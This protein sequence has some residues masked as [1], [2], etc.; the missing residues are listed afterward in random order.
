M[1]IHAFPC[2]ALALALAPP[3]AA[4]TATAEPAIP[5]ALPASAAA[6]TLS[7]GD[8]L[9]ITVWRKPELSGDFT[10]SADSTIGSPFYMDLKVTGMP[11]SSVADRV[12]THIAR[13]E[14]E[15]R[16]LVE[17]LFRVSIAGEVRQP[18]LYSVRPETTIAQAIMKSGGPTI[19]ARLDRVVLWRGGQQLTVDLTRPDAG[20]AGSPIRSGDQLLV[21]RRTSILRDYVAPMS[22]VIGASAAIAN[23]ILRNWR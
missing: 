19:F 12:R 8:E 4:Q 11:L 21:P 7:P 3:L 18:N 20:L 15:P 16:V 1:R 10:I 9:R 13:Y 22:S 6:T 23:L 17:P 14:A 5:A 2:L